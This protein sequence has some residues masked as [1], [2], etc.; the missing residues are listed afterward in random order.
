MNVG[1]LPKARTETKKEKSKDQREETLLA[2]LKK[3][4]KLTEEVHSRDQI[5]MNKITT[6][7]K[8]QK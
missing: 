5:V 7:E 8:A 2:I 3:I 6:L 4:E 1:D